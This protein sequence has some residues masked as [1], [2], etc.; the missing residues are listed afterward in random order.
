MLP[1]GSR[2]MP[3]DLHKWTSETIVCDINKRFLPTQY[4]EDCDICILLG[5]FEYLAEPDFLVE[6]LATYV[7][8]IVGSCHHRRMPAAFRLQRGWL[9][10]LS[11]AELRAKLETAGFVIDREE[12]IDAQIVFRAHNGA[13]SSRCTLARDSAS[14]FT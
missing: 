13:L 2:Y 7:P 5:V 14:S 3:M 8:V 11:W 10:A 6:K 4:L 1:E 9:N 12:S